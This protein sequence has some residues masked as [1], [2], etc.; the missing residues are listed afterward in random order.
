MF[1]SDAG[2][3]LNANNNLGIAKSYIYECKRIISE[4]GLIADNDDSSV[5]KSSI[6]DCDIDTLVTKVECDIDTLVTK[7]E[8]TKN[9]LLKIDQNFATKYM[10]L[11][12]KQISNES[13]D[14]SNMT[15]EQYQE[16]SMYDREYH[17]SLLFT[18]E[19]YEEQ[20]MLTDE[21]KEVLAYERLLSKSYDIQDKM[22][23]VSES[24]DEY[25]GLF[26]QYGT[27]SKQ[28]IQAN[29]NLTD[30][31]KTKFLSS[32]DTEYNTKHGEIET[33]VS[34]RK[35]RDID[36]SELQSLIQQKEDNDDFWHPIIES[37]LQDAIIDKKKK[38]GI[39]TNSEIEYSNMSGG[40]KFWEGTKTFG[41]SLYTGLFGVTESIVDGGAMIVG[42][43]GGIWSSDFKSQVGDFVK[44]DYAGELYKGIT[45][46]WDINSVSASGGAHT[47]GNAIGSTVGYV[48]LSYAAPWV[49]ATAMGLSAMGSSSQKALI[50]GAS[51]DEAFGT[52]LVSGAAG[53]ITGGALSKFNAFAGANTTSLLQ[54]GRNTL[55]GGGISAVEPVV[56]SVAEYG[57]YGKDMVDE[58][59]NPIYDN[60]WDYYVKSGGAANTVM[61]F[62]VG[63]LSSGI[64]SGVGLKKLNDVYKSDGFKTRTD[65]YEWFKDNCTGIKSDVKDA[66][67]EHYSFLKSKGYK[68][69][70]LDFVSEYAS[71]NFTTP[72]GFAALEAEVRQTGAV[73]VV[74]GDGLKNVSKYGSLGR[75]SDGT[76]KGAS[77]GTSVKAQTEMEARLASQGAS[78]LPVEERAAKGITTAS[79]QNGYYKIEYTPQFFEENPQAK[80]YPN[81]GQSGINGASDA[82]MPGGY[83]YDLHSNGN[84]V[85]EVCIGDIQ[86]N[87]AVRHKINWYVNSGS[88]QD[89]NLGRYD[90]HLKGIVIKKVQ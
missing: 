78:S 64:A 75:P 45:N 34:K 38:L 11:L 25:L 22:S 2:L 24:S 54:V 55:I 19:Q 87:D 37:E 65:G 13:L 10:S 81:S 76:K 28:I 79:P 66:L 49:S 7:V 35:E 14:V 85:P 23:L 77:F 46:Q 82:A 43:V 1:K 31:E 33:A 59:G 60:I 5:L 26:E 47:Y 44:K 4:L 61:S 9:N 50:S 29:P 48:A 51:Y 40:E 20:G 8:N 74:D 89:L 84:G 6:E 88:T 30:D 42:E 62:G 41:A 90:R 3:F 39:A 21:M 71:G 17:Q 15:D 63:G 69:S 57:F 18:L 86:L 73:T 32:Y 83:T 52:G 72:S 12:E 53:A 68:G 67:S 16:Y 80:I 27:I 70:Y 58:N 56:N 36:Y